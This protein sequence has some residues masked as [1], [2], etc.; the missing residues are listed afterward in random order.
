MKNTADEIFSILLL[1]T[2]G[3]DDA[4]LESEDS[5]EESNEE[6]QAENISISFKT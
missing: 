2:K 6:F 4:P 3:S 1:E 5:D